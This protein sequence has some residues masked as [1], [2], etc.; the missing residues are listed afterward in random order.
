M[1]ASQGSGG[2]RLRLLL[3]SMA[4]A[5]LLGAPDAR[6]AYTEFENFHLAVVSRD[7]QVALGFI[8][9]FPASRFVDD[10]MVMLP[11]QLARQL[12][13]DL[14][15]GATRAQTACRRA[16][17]PVGPR[18][19][20]E[21]GMGDD[22]ISPAAGPEMRGQQLASARARPAGATGERTAAA[23]ARI[24]PPGAPTVASAD[25][26]GPTATAGRAAEP[27]P[28]ARQAPAPSVTG[29]GGDPGSDGGGTSAP[30]SHGKDPGSDSGGDAGSGGRDSRN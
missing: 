14:P 29:L 24:L 30:T 22:A 6:A 16:D 28:K 1:G 13:A 10:L 9:A 12:C 11:P 21:G 27:A 15:D 20:A 4:L 7:E 19:F 8:A 3:S 17:L 18:A 23:M 5:C 25:D 2:R 26:D